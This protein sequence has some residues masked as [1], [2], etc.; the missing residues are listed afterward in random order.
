MKKAI[1][2]YRTAVLLFLLASVN[3]ARAD[4]LPPPTFIAD[5]MYLGFPVGPIIGLG[6]AAAAVTS[7]LWLRKQGLRMWTAAPICILAYLLLNMAVYAL[8]E[9]RGLIRPTG[10][11]FQIAAPS[12]P[13]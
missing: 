4:V 3:Q 5:S 10:R 9:N 6:L 11:R 7:F 1:G 2:S 8:A 13:V 12:A